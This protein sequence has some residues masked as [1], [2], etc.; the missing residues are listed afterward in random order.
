MTNYTYVEKLD[1]PFPYQFY[2]SDFTGLFR[3]KLGYTNINDIAIFDI[4]PIK[5]A[6][7][8][9]NKI[10]QKNIDYKLSYEVKATPFAQNKFTK[11]TINFKTK[12]NALKFK[13]RFG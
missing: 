3:V 2:T 1:D 5:D 4:D 7:I 13:M 11:T 9:F 12:D 10:G 8:W 6:E